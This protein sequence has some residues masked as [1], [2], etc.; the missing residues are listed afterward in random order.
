MKRFPAIV[1]SALAVVALSNPTISAQTKCPPEVASAKAILMA[2]GGQMEA[3]GNA[4]EAPPPRSMSGNTSRDQD[5]RA[6]RNQDVQAPRNQDVQAPRNQDVQAPRNQDVQA[7]RNQDVQAPRNQDVQAP[8]NRQDVQAP[9]NR[10]DVQAPRNQDVQAPRNQSARGPS[11]PGGTTDRQ[12][13]KKAESL[14]KEAEAACRMGDSARASEKAM[15]A[16]DIL[17]Q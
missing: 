1:T 10:Q 17:K 4:Q 9:R 8:R 6:H 15:A 13:A 5:T 3:S 2:R 12:D 7:P 11:S 14:V 16:L